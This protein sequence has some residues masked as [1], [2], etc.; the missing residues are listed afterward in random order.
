MVKAYSYKNYI[1]SIGT[2]SYRQA[3]LSYK[4]EIALQALES[5]N[6][7]SDAEWKTRQNEYLH[8]IDK[9]NVINYSGKLSKK[10]ARAITSSLNQ[11]GLCSKRERKI[12]DAGNVLLNI[13]N[14]KENLQNDFYLSTTS[15]FY[16]LQ[17]LK[18]KEVINFIYILISLD[19]NLTEEEFKVFIMTTL[20]DANFGEV[21]LTIEA[22]RE[23]REISVEKRE[24]FLEEYLYK[25]MLSMNNYQEIYQDFVVNNIIEDDE[26]QR[27]GVNRKGIRYD[28]PIANLYLYLKSIHSHNQ[29]NYEIV[30]QLTLDNRNSFK[31]WNKILFGETAS[32]KKQKQ[33]F[34]NNFKLFIQS[35]SE[36]ELRD[37]FFKNLHLNRWQSNIED[38]YDLNKRMLLT[39]GVFSFLNGTVK[40][41][42]IPY[43]VFKYNLN[44]LEI[45]ILENK[46]EDIEK[47]KKFND[48]YDRA[49]VANKKIIADLVAE[50]IDRHVDLDNVDDYIREKENEEFENFIKEKFDKNKI[51]KIFR[52]IRD[53]YNS[54][55]LTEIKK[56]EKEIKELC[57][58]KDASI[59]T[60][61]EYITA[62]AWFYISDE[63]IN[64]LQILNLSLSAD[65]LPITH[66]GGGQADLIVEY[67]DYKKLPDHNLLIEVSLTKEQNQRRAEMEPVTRHLGEYRIKNSDKETYCIFLTHKLD[68]NTSIHFRSQKYIPYTYNDEWVDG[69]KIIPLEIDNIVDTL[70][71]DKSYDEI[72]WISENA[73][74]SDV[75]VREWW[76][77]EVK[78]KFNFS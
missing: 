26:I 9:F 62:I 53:Q 4:L 46:A 10:D 7:V 37:W 21:K 76:I 71:F 45:I 29:I 2:T 12:T 13:T 1:W 27:I 20:S 34:E 15:Y 28:Q 30:K 19:N 48:L 56:H 24:E 69:N 52:K 64:P 3:N 78:D 59:P 35:L 50:N 39:T 43:L 33:Y 44:S 65:Y 60:I 72:F 32:E 66:A 54:N 67:K 51:I 23:Y 25:K 8:H 41:S 11:L 49:F 40:L 55:K 17:L 63:K 73:F 14:N 75:D 74:N 47:F 42:T 18:K 5:L 58:T 31:K 6:N 38:Y 22:I 61:F 57:M 36:R 68:T 70:V 16:F 77:R